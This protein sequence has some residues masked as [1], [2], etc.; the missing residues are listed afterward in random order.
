MSPIFSFPINTKNLSVQEKKVEVDPGNKILLTFEEFDIETVDNPQK[1][2]P[3][4]YLKIENEKYCGYNP[5]DYIL[6]E[7][8]VMN[9]NFVSDDSTE[10]TGYKAN[11]WKGNLRNQPFT[12][13]NY[14]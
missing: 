7:N 13:T 6:S 2:C 4:D 12:L 11:W 3:Y 10:R 1:K 9:I 14:L 5:P 8:N